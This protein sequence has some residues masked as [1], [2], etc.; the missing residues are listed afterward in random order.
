MQCVFFH[1]RIIKEKGLPRKGEAR[2][3]MPYPA[4]VGLPASA[5]YNWIRP[6]MDAP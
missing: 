2:D 5:A 3:A 4:A 1:T 6:P